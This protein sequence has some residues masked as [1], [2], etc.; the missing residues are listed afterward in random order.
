[1]RLN[2]F[3][4]PIDFQ[5]VS[6]LHFSLYVCGVVK[7]SFSCSSFS[8]F[9]ISVYRLSRPPL[10]K[11]TLVRA[12]VCVRVNYVSV[13]LTLNSSANKFRVCNFSDNFIEVI[14]PSKTVRCTLRRATAKLL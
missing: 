6:V 1:M 11:Y 4:I 7:V 8:S 13:A 2:N 3:S 14:A 5:R 10:R 12:F 9:R